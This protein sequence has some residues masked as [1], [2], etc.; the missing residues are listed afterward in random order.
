VPLFSAAE[1]VG[2]I[3]ASNFAEDGTPKIGVV[4]HVIVGSAESALSEFRTA[5]EEL[6]AHFIVAGPGDA[7]P[8]GTILQ[9]LDTD[10]VAFA[11]EAGNW[12]PTAYIAIEFSVVPATPMSM[13]QVAAGAAICAW[14]AKTHGVPLVGPVAHGSPGVT[15]HCF[16]NG[17]ADPAWGNHSCPGVIRLRQ[18]PAMVAQAIALNAPPAP[19]PPPTNSPRGANMLHT[20]PVETDIDGNGWELTTIP[21]ADY[22]GVSVEGSDPALPSAGGDGV[23]W[24]TTVR[25]QDRDNMVLVSVTDCPPSSVVNVFVLATA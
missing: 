21:W 9:V 7:W 18:V 5:G 8:D 19:L 16:P 20:I 22:M 1:F 14:A 25:V 13:A 4:V 11:Q 12:P 17:Q 15:T 3:P 6:S 10:L 2:P 24:H 23:Y